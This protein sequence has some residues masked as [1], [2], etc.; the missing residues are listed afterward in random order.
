MYTKAELAKLPFVPPTDQEVEK[1]VDEVSAGI[2]MSG[3]S[4]YLTGPPCVCT[5]TT[6]NQSPVCIDTTQV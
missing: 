5:L 1:E 3:P 6:A 4:S 2:F